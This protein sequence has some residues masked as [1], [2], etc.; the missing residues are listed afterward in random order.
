MSLHPLDPEI[1][2]ATDDWFYAEHPRGREL[3]A[4]GTRTPLD[5]TSEE[6]REG[7]Q[8]WI[9]EY[10]RR[11]AEKQAG[12]GDD[13][14]PDDPG[15]GDD[16]TD[17]AEGCNC[18][19]D[20]VI[21]PHCT[22]IK[23]GDSAQFSVSELDGAPAGSYVWTTT[24][25]KLTL[26][27]DHAS[28]VRVISTGMPSASRDAETLTVVRSQ[29]GCADITKV[30][31]LTVGKVTFSKAAGQAYGYDDFDTPLD[32]DDD[33][34]SVKRDADTTVH[35]EMEGG[36]VGADFDFECADAGIATC[37]EAPAMLPSFDLRIDGGST[38]KG[39]TVLRAK[40]RCPSAQVFR[41]IA[42][43]TYKERE[44]KVVVGKFH[45]STSAGT[46]LR[47]PNA[48][49]A[50]HQPTINDKVKEAVAR[51]DITNF[52]AANAQTD[53]AFDSD[54][55]GAL[56]YD[57]AAGGGTELTRIATAFTGARTT[58]RIRIAIIRDMK[59]YFYLASAAAAGDTTITVRGSRA[60]DP[61][62]AM[63]LGT[64][65]SQENITIASMSGATLTLSAPLAHAHPAGTPLEFPAGGW[66]SDPIMII[67][68]SASLDTIKWTMAHEAGHRDEGLDLRDIVDQT[69]FMHWMQSW[70]DYRLRYC[71]RTKKHGT[72]TENQWETI[73]RT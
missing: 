13:D 51:F 30:I 28:T 36:I 62:R 37:E 46:A 39:S 26:A 45:D 47:F 42:V 72:G 43:H 33:H 27:N 63:P 54:G 49:Y 44:V 40:V 4:D 3:C 64:G 5:A 31:H 41:E 69:D 17:P 73:P 67:E 16:P 18:A 55:N 24:S 8:A 38:D 11:L 56:S 66:S 23:A 48:D 68:G 70:T 71:P 57:I 19:A 58:G 34:V 9:A 32:P 61:G 6:D 29:T 10:R 12:G 60:F 20:F 14:G 35:V 52:D 2:A 59:S 50:G 1:V 65:A 15:G 53:V 21:D 25:D 22:I 7:R